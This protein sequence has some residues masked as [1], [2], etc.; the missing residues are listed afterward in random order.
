MEIRAAEWPDLG[1]VARCE[2]DAFALAP[3]RV[4][5]DIAK[6]HSVLAA[7][8]RAGEIH[9]ATHS[10]RVIGYVSF[11]TNYEHLFVGAIAVLPERQRQG[12]GSHLLAFAERTAADRDLD[13]VSLHS[14]GMIASNTRFYARRGYRETDRCEGPNY[15]RI[16]YS[17]AIA[18]PTAQ[19]A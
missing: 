4:D 6:A 13:F 1:C 3:R 10:G 5:G 17:K 15:L 11:A 18:P 2:A 12:V 14:D 7:Q 8:I 19:A 16:Y 9:V